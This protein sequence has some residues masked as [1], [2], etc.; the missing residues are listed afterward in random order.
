MLPPGTNGT[1]QRTGFCGNAALSAARN[2]AA[3]NMVQM[4][5]VQAHICAILRMKGKSPPMR[6]DG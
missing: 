4:A 1:I 2:G 3:Q 6:F 5:A